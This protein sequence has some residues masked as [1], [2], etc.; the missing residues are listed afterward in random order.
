MKATR[1]A[2]PSSR[3][4]ASSGCRSGPS[5]AITSCTPSAPATASS[6]RS[7]DFC[8]VKLAGECERGAVQTELAP[9]LVALGAAS[10]S[11][12]AG[13]GSTRHPLGRDAPADGEL[14]EIRARREDVRRMPQLDVTREPQ[15]ART[16]RPPP[17]WNSST[18]PSTQAAATRA[19]ERGIGG[20]L[21]DVRLARDARAERARA[22]TSPS[23]TRRR[24]SA[25]ARCT[26]AAPR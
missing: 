19:L 2:I 5:P 24:P 13:F 17:R 26:S 25:R 3:A 15:T 12:G 16:P 4:S 7:S 21:H 22:R 10:D 14:A 6:A 18:S 20:Q 8:A 1:S 9:Q 23:C 11:E